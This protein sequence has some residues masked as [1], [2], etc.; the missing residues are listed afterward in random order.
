KIPGF[1]PDKI[2]AAYADGGPR[3]TVATVKQLFH[4]VTGSD[5]AINGVI[6]VN[7]AGF[8]EAVDYVGGVYVDVD[9]RYYND[10]STAAP[11]QVFAPCAGRP[12]YQK[13]RG[14]DAPD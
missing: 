1:K 10:N 2:N 12:G 13:L 8:R 9:R 5:F 11:G 6:N 4:D 7:F 14:Q 3:K